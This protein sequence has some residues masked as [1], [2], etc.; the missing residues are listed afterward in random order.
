M[1]DVPRAAGFQAQSI[2]GG[3]AARR[4]TDEIL[5]NIV[6]GRV[7]GDAGRVRVD[8]ACRSTSSRL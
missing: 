7:L 4:R 6:A 2:G 3:A 8:E 1:G 5:R